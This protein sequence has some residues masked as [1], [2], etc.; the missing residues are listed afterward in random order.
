MKWNIKSALLSIAYLNRRRSGLTVLLAVATAPVIAFASLPARDEDI[1]CAS[2]DVIVGTVLKA[3][4]S[5]LPRIDALCGYK[6]WDCSSL[7]SCQDDPHDITLRIRVSSVLGTKANQAFDPSPFYTRAEQ[8]KVSVGDIIN[9]TTGLFNNVCQPGIED[10]QGWFSVNPPVKGASPAES[11]SPELLRRFYVGKDFVLSLSAIRYIGLDSNAPGI[12]A[13]HPD[14]FSSDIWRMERLAWV[15]A[16]L[17]QSKGSS[18]PK[19]K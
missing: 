3:T 7:S 13:D 17:R 6:P 5:D 18:C 8:V 15:K 9:V 10:H 16:T 2:T 11:V 1:L 12:Y 14:T 19:P 4:R